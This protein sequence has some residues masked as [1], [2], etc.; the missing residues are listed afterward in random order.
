MAS[1]GAEDDHFARSIEHLRRGDFSLS[2]ALFADHAAS[3]PCQVTRWLA[4]GRF[5]GI[6]DALREAFTCACFLGKTSVVKSL[7]DQGVHA[8][9]G[10]ATGM[11][12]LHWAV[13]RG[14]LETVQLLLEARP[15][16]EVRNMYGG[17]ALGAAIWAAI[18]ESRP[19]H[20]AII[21]A[22]LRAGAQVET[23][24]YPTGVQAI[25]VLLERYGDRSHD[26]A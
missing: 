23:I 24:D 18:H 7:L 1:H 4:E 15:S 22:L 10:A 20:V 17:T 16:L 3:H 5:R 14:Q 9:G 26:D 11:N 6:P 21:E 8:E 2:E 25:D 19:S 13:N 12:A